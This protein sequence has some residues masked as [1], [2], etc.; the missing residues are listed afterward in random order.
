L[1]DG[2]ATEGSPDGKTLGSSDGGL[3]AH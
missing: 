3:R 2:S 1:S